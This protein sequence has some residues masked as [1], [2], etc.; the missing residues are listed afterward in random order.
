MSLPLENFYELHGATEPR[1]LQQIATELPDLPD[2][3]INEY[4]GTIKT[5]KDQKGY[6]FRKIVEF[7][8][9]HGV[10]TNRSAVYRAYKQPDD[11][12]EY[13]A[14]EPLV[15]DETGEIVEP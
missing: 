8:A 10:P 12:E 4:R 5:L 13:Q 15:D 1:L 11:L 3:N 2:L 9:E 6:S 7:L 14:D